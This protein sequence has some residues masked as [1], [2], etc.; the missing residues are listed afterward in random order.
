MLYSRS[1]LVTHLKY[2]SVYMSIK[3]SSSLLLHV[4]RTICGLAV[5]KLKSQLR[6][7]P[8]SENYFSMHPRTAWELAE[9]QI[10]RSHPRP[11]ESDP[12][13]VEACN[14]CF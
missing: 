5:S 11:T 1:L 12:L 4:V 6:M 2:S 14:L 3:V 9:M 8:K 7:R 13:R 10:L